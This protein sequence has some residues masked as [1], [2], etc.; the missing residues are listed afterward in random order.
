MKEIYESIMSQYKLNQFTVILS[1]N[2][3]WWEIKPE[4]NLDDKLNEYLL[5]KW[6]SINNK[7]S[8]VKF[9][10]DIYVPNEEPDLSTL[11]FNS[12]IH[13]ISPETELNLE[14]C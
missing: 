1:E 7:K 11:E 5:Y 12:I 3:N 14:C 6:C 9:I 10:T 2:N 8:Y 4:I 13:M